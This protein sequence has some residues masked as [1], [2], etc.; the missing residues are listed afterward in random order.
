MQ[1]TAKFG[2]DKRHISFTQ[3]QCEE[4]HLFS[5]EQDPSQL[6]GPEDGNGDKENMD[7]MCTSLFLEQECIKNLNNHFH[8]NK[9]TSV[10]LD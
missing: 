5:V 2:G 10:R 4:D 9:S 8:N 3:S 6:K 7:N 1:D